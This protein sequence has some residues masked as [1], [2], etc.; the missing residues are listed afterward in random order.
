M[1]QELLGPSS[2][3]ALHSK[4][5]DLPEYCNGT[6]P[7]CPPDMYIQ[8]GTPCKDGASCYFP[9]IQWENIYK[10][11]VLQ[12]HVLLIQTR[13]GDKKCRGL[14]YHGGVPVADVGAVEDG[15]P[16]GRDVLCINRTSTS[17][18]LLNY[19]CNVTKCHGRGVCNNLQNCH[20]RYGWFPPSCEGEGFGGSIDSGTPPAKN[21]SRRAPMECAVF[22]YP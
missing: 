17:V 15:M 16:C 5:C 7:W 19:D 22:L 6:S 2:S 8:D 4:Y 3:N 12:D 13:V 10:V 14:D 21:V 9:Q 11:P 18:S 1:L 20:C